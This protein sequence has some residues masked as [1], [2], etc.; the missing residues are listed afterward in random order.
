[1]PVLLQVDFPYSGPF[2]AEMAAA[3]AGL[4]QSIAAEP[5]FLWKI[6]T[7]SSERNEAGGI[8][9]FATKADAEAYIVMHT[10][11]LA[12][13]GITGV[14]AKIFEVN[15]EL[16]KIDK[17]PLGG[18]NWVCITAS[19]ADLTSSSRVSLKQIPELSS[20]TTTF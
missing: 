3:M 4:A 18:F 1:M 9:M 6:W 11:R 17:G 14:R 12:G 2:G 8:Y 16:S 5:G 10:K 20:Y 15:E 19:L 13:F 7:E